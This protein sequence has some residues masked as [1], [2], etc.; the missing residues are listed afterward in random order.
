[1][2]I[3]E[4]IRDVDCYPN[5]SIAYRIFIMFVTVASAERSLSKLKLLKNYLKSTM[6]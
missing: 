3:F 5:V 4:H 2:E 6:S 1:M